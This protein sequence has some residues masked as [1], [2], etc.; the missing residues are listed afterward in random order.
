[1]PD[2]RL[3]LMRLAALGLAVCVG[4]AL[5]APGSRADP[6][7]NDRVAWL[8]ERLTDSPLRERLTACLA[9]PT[10]PSTFSIGHRGAPLYYPE[11]TRESYLEA[12][13]QGA[14]IIECDVTFTRDRALVCRHDQ[15]D[16]HRTTNML[17]TD[18]AT[19]CSQ[20]FTPA[21]PRSGRPASARCCAGDLSAAEF[22][23]LCGRRDQ[24]D[25]DATS[26]AAY[27]S[28]GVADS[29][30]VG[31]SCPRLL[32]HDDSITLFR[33]LGVAM[34][35]ELKVPADTPAFTSEFT[36]NDYASALLE[37]YRS[38]GIAPA[39]LWPQ[40]FD[41]NVVQYWLQAYP[42][43]AAQIVWLDGRYADATFDPADPDSWSPSMAELR[44]LGLRHLAPP[45][46]VLLTV[47]NGSIVPSAYARAARAAGLEL[48]T[49][50]LERPGTIGTDGGFY[51]SPLRGALEDEGDI[52]KVLDVLA[53]D[54]G[55]IGVF[56]DWPATTTFYANCLGL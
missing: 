49:W 36:L 26:V 43:F 8:L 46:P 56:S 30:L 42:E 16:L 11:H 25:P 24:V 35:P 45:I 40:S 2:S 12:A 55:V 52:F 3:R 7:P 4:L 15:C 32:T 5:S 21:D 19:R 13:R 47:E 53:Q 31:T 54:A 38:A 6:K 39:E 20:P 41:L 44:S 1:M 14:A 51:L 37:A 33:E 48:I 17:E 18:L 23:S 34:T 22:L 28:P 27:L 29:D 10:L 50:T 9:S